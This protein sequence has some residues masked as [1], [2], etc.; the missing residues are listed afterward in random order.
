M[1]PDPAP[2]VPS[3]PLMGIRQGCSRF[4]RIPTDVILP[5]TPTFMRSITEQ[6][7][8]FEFRYRFTGDVEWIWFYVTAPTSA[9]TH[10]ALTERPKR[11][12]QQI[13]SEG[14]GNDEFNKGL[15]GSR[16][17]YPIKKLFVL[18]DPIPRIEI[19]RDYG[20]TVKHRAEKAT[21]AMVFASKIWLNID[22]VYEQQLN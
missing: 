10:I 4:E 17:A 1:S 20:I 11:P 2:V 5:I 21:A 14:I 9:I 15:K 8:T 13:S 12:G 18:K 6:L 16:H 22:L 7:K 3:Q 19:I